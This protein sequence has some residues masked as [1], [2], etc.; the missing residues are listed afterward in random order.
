M[1]QSVYFHVGLERTA[2]TF[3]Q[4]RVFPALKGI[5]YVPKKD[6]R[7]ARKIIEEA[8]PQKVLVSHEFDK[9][10]EKE[11][12]AFARHTP[13]AHPIIAFRRQH[14]WIASQYK[15]HLKKGFTTP[16][17]RFIDLEKDAGYYK[18]ESLCYYKK[19]EVL[20]KS[21]TKK[22]LILFFSDLKRN[23][24]SFFD[25]ISE[26]TGS[27]YEKAAID[28]RKKHVS[29]SEKELQVLR[30]AGNYIALR[31]KQKYGIKPYDT[32]LRLRGKAI[33]YSILKA[34]PLLA[35]ALSHDSP[36]IPP[37]RLEEVREYFAE[38]WNRVCVYAEKYQFLMQ[39]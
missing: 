38:D 19:I 20:R 26:F 2:T 22:P 21:F 36:L 14:D 3:L 12:R 25:Q 13:N 11:V 32:W 30:R 9:S 10:F 24:F 8:K 27:S 1:E 35:P 39:A 7:R 33:R 31:P 29:Y 5:R 16:F 6:F 37:D 17:S 34:A 18:K 28:I 23:P 4:K 15:R